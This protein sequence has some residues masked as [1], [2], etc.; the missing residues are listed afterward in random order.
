MEG[1]ELLI[2]MERRMSQIVTLQKV[3]MMQV[4]EENK[5]VLANLVTAQMD[6]GETGTGADI[7]PEYTPQYAAFKGFSTPDLKLEGDFHRSVFAR[8][9]SDGIEIG[10]TDFKTE[11]LIAKYGENILSLQDGSINEFNEDVLLPEMLIKNEKFLEI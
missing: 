3:F 5:A 6:R 11:R 7:R 9:E 8:A 1:T 4:I 2:D 10:A